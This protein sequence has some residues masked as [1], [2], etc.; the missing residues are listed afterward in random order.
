MEKF[1][2]REICHKNQAKPNLESSGVFD[3]CHIKLWIGT[4]K[5]LPKHPSNENAGIFR[6]RAVTYVDVLATVVDQFSY[7]KADIYVCMTRL[8]FY[9]FFSLTTFN[10]YYLVDDGTGIISCHVKKNTAD[11]EKIEQ[12]RLTLQNDS[13]IMVIFYNLKYSLYY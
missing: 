12:L 1:E 6:N 13:S 8:L 9:Y 2:N 4:I 3:N 10:V 11:V 7:E 5:N